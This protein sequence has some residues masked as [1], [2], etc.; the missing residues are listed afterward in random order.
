MNAQA[1]KRNRRL[2][3]IDDN[4]SIHA[5]FRK[6]LAEGGSAS[7]D[8][9]RVGAELFGDTVPSGRKAEFEMSTAR[10]GEEGLVAVRE[11]L[12]CGSPFA[13]AFVDV[14]MPPGW[15][16]IET[17]ARIWEVDP[18]IQI[19]LCTAYSDYSWEEITD[20]LGSS[21]RLV[22]LKK[23][24]DAVE[25][26]QL[27][28]ALTEKWALQRRVKSEFQNLEQLVGER[29]CELQKTNT[30]LEE[31]IE[32]HRCTEQALRATQEKLNHFLAKSPAVLYSLKLEHGQVVP[33]WVSDNF[34]GLT[35]GEVEGW[36]R[37]TPALEYVAEADRPAVAAAM[38]TLLERGALSLEYR[39]RRKDGQLRWIRDDRKLLQ[40]E[41]GRPLEII[42]CWT[43]ITEQ[44]LLQDQLRQAQKMESVG[45]LAGGVAHD[46]NNLLMV[47]QGYIEMLL[48]TEPFSDAVAESLRQVYGAAEKAGN[49]TR[50]LLAFSRKQIMQPQEVDLN[51]LVGTAAKLLSRTL[52]EHIKVE[53]RCAANL[54]CVWA[55]RGMID[56]VI[57]NLAVN[58]R[59]A[60]PRRGELVF[61]ASVCEVDESCLQ[62]HSDARP[63]R[64]VRLSVADSGCGIAKENLP[65][66]FEPFFTTKEVG[67]GTGLGLATVY[68][69]VKQHGGWIEVESE[70]G[71]GTTFNIFLPAAAVRAAAGGQSAAAPEVR[72]G[73]ETILVVED[74][75]AVRGL[76]RTSLERYGYRVCTA[77]SGAEALQQWSE[78]LNEIDLLI[79]DVV[80]PEGV[81]GWDVARQ[82][83]ARNP[84]LR[85]LYMSGYTSSMSAIESGAVSTGTSLFLQKPF[86]PKKLAEAVRT[87]L[88]GTP[89]NLAPS[90][91][92]GLAAS[93]R[94][95]LFA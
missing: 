63:G 68:G 30:Q 14:R 55:D 5:D 7:R 13:L 94:V 64:F 1:D 34:A 59:D 62:K 38:T 80:M 69:I 32:E 90:F 82:L 19:V 78:R 39:V 48:N 44:R 87:C 91:P 10:Q 49:L 22:I 4:P 29:T 72:G 53:A 50:Q 20:R 23:P 66:L 93:D 58:A 54:P 51:E 46:F 18:D 76:V 24:F 60:M 92:P 88:E 26:L 28:S 25:V 77:N 8:L 85:I 35:G 31:T 6:I 2:L 21:D 40:D 12:R 52:G 3:V 16:G 17:S 42:G 71:K 65:R 56:Q 89:P 73:R 33:A 67:K 36:Y 74:E 61:S 27:A 43:E 75:P 83:Q 95:R 45:Q 86:K 9:A 84:S 47:I 57:M 37:Q 11:A 81:S 79:T 70:V 15:D 41:A